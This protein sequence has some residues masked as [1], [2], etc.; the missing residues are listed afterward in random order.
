IAA[1]SAERLMAVARTVNGE[2]RSDAAIKW[3]SDKPSIAT[4]DAAGLVTG[5]APGSA[6]I[7]ATSGEAIGKVT[8]EVKRDAVRRLSIQPAAG[9]ARTGD[10]VRFKASDSGKEAPVRWS[11]TGGGGSIYADGA[12]VA[13]KAGTYVVTA[14]SGQHSASS[15]V[16]VRPRNVEREVEI[17]SHVPMPDV[18]MS[19]EWIIGHHA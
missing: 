18:Q 2:P 9:D 12:F 15:S 5:I 14:S 11:V 17:V 16:V 8:V 13:E 3:A 7:K 10:V 4:V 19:E 6:T 1:G